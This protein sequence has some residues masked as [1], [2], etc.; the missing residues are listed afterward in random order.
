[1]A[2]PLAPLAPLALLALLALLPGCTTT[3]SHPAPTVSDPSSPTLL[4]APAA[5]PA[6]PAQKPTPQEEA[7]TW[8]VSGSECTHATAQTEQAYTA[9]FQPQL[10]GVTYAAAAVDPAT[11]GQPWNLTIDGSPGLISYEATFWAGAV[12]PTG[13]LVTFQVG[14]PPM[15]HDTTI[16]GTVPADADFV[17][18]TACGGAS[19]NGSAHYVAQRAGLADLLATLP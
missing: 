1:M 13:R 9:T 4:P 12:G 10:Q 17:A 14:L 18:V 6:A 11:I 19:A 7:L 3:P 5:E 8:L 2:R 15:E 16:D